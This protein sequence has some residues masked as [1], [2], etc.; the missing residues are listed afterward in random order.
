MADSI[1]STNDPRRTKV[2]FSRRHATS[3]AHLLSVENKRAR[4]AKWRATMYSFEAER[5]NRS[6]S[7]QLKVLDQR[8]GKGKGAKKERKR[9]LAQLNNPKKTKVKKKEKGN[10]Q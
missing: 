5:A 10:S 9:L 4:E 1:I 3:E 8:L 2:W 7:E 6:P